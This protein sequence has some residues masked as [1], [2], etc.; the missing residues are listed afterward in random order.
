MGGNVE[1]GRRWEGTWGRDE[2][3]ADL[4]GGMRWEGTWGGEG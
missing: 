2:V 3:E 1:G 4:G